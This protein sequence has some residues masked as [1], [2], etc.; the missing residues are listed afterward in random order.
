MLFCPKCGR[1]MEKWREGWFRC[2]NCG[3]GGTIELLEWLRK[4]LTFT[5]QVLNVPLSGVAGGRPRG[6]GARA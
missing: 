2:K 4:V 3:V 5:K 6:G 1:E